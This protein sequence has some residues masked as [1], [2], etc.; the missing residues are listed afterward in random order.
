MKPLRNIVVATDFSEQA[1]KATRYAIELAQRLDARVELVHVWSIPIVS[2]PD[3]V[4][5]L[6]AG[7]I[8]DLAKE[9]QRGMDVALERHTVPGTPVT[10]AVVCGDPR[11]AVIEAADKAKAD[12][13]V[14]G[15]HGR[16]GLRRAVLGSLAETVVRLAKCPVLVVR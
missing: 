15:T 14:L 2:Y 3:I 10:G 12:L 4:V 13:L 6:P 16:R 11:D 9:A 5:P 8:D 7:Y 1:E